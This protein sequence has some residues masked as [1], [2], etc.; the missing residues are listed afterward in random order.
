MGFCIGYGSNSGF[1]FSRS[2]KQKLVTL[3]STE[4]E[5][6]SATETAKDVVYF[7][8]VLEELGFPTIKPTSIK[9]DNQSLIALATKF[10]GNHKRVRHFLSRINYLIEQVDGKVITLDYVDTKLN[11]ADQLTK[12]LSEPAFVLARQRLMGPQRNRTNL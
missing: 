10:S 8:N 2:A 4:S 7:R 11:T 12:P 5:T 1:F 3:S 9:V 6:Y